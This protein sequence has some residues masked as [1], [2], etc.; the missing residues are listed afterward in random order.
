MPDDIQDDYREHAPLEKEFLKVSTPFEQFFR[1]QTT[2]GL[3]LVIA[4]IVALIM[5][6]SEYAELYASFNKAPLTISLADMSFSHSVHYWVNDGL[7]AIFFFLLGLEIKYE[8]L[9]GDLKDIRDSSLVIAMAIGGMVFPACIYAIVISMSGM[10]AMQGWGIP[11]ATDTAFALGILALLG[12]KAPP[13]AAV[14]LSA[15]AIVD[16]MGAVAV[17]GLFYTDYIDVSALS[18]AGATLVILFGMN[19]LGIRR[20]VFYLIGGLVLWYFVLQSG[21]HATTAGILAAL[22]VPTKPY[23]ETRWFSKRMRRLLDTFD[24]RDTPGQSIVEDLQQHKL[25]EQAGRIA[26]QTTAPILR[27]GHTLDRPVSLLIL[28]LFAFLNAGVAIPSQLTFGSES[29]VMV[30]VMLGLVIGKVCGISLCAWAAVKTGIARLP[31]DMTFVH[32]VALACMAGIGFTMSLFISAL[33]FADQP[34]LEAQAKLGI[35][36]GSLIAATFGTVLFLK[37][38]PAAPR[39]EAMGDDGN[40]REGEKA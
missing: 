25:A 1:S 23:A 7:M 19:I 22:T 37:S 38:S 40:N 29:A 14:A 6:N 9:V 27:W 5:A 28:P 26:R 20:P 3:V 33:A 18:L 30:G 32:V 11:M 34:L 39:E 21:V 36:I 17:I 15:L 24:K 2:T 35:L 31:S 13:S 12:S 10:D 4:A 16:D 8:V